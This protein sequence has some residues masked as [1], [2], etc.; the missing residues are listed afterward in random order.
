MLV[1][2][3]T[4]L[5]WC[6]SE[7]VVLAPAT[8]VP[9]DSE[10]RVWRACAVSL[11]VSGLRLFR[12]RRNRK[13]IHPSTESRN[14]F[15]SPTKLHGWVRS[16]SDTRLVPKCS[17]ALSQWVRVRALFSMEES[18]SLGSDSADWMNVKFHWKLYVVPYWLLDRFVE[19]ERQCVSGVHSQPQ[20]VHLHGVNGF[21][22]FGYFL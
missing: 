18:Y 15:T 1:R 13:S 16:P 8:A 9:T 3:R 20:Y 6:V 14:T 17:I 11:F 5:Y 21:S 7:Y 2:E 4:M 12:P 22:L 19:C 10:R